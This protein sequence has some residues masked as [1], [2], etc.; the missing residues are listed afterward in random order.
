MDTTGER[1]RAGCAMRRQLFVGG[2][3]LLVSLTSLARGQAFT[4]TTGL[5]GLNHVQATNNPGNVKS[6]SGGA[7]AG[8][9]DNDGHVDLF[10]TVVD[11]ADILYRNQGNGQFLPFNT[12][13]F[14]AG[15]PSNGAGFGDVD[16]DGDLDL[17]V[18]AVD[19]SQHYLYIN[20]GTNQQG[21]SLGFV[22]DAQA[23]GASLNNGVN[24]FGFGMAFGD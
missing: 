13:V 6:M 11:G 18:T 10:V 19:H 1:K 5:A 4:E 21:Q 16:N 14:D 20:Q 15:I 8:D 17:Y 22:E 2:L 9:F 3:I 12:N 24:N 7:A 23:R